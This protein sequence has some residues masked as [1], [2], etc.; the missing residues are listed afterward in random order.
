MLSR[1][2]IAGTSIFISA[3]AGLG[4]H[5]YR[6]GV[7][8]SNLRLLAPWTDLTSSAD[9]QC[10]GLWVKRAQ[11]DPALRCYLTTDVARLCNPNERL[12]LANVLRAYR[13]DSAM[14]SWD[15]IVSVVKPE[16]MPAAR[17]EE[18]QQLQDEIRA[19]VEGRAAPRKEMSALRK[20]TE[21]PMENVSKARP[22]TLDAALDVEALDPGE[23]SG[24]LR[25]IALGGFMLKT[26]FG[27]L[28]GGMV[29]EAFEGVWV[30]RACNGALAESASKLP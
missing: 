11:N 4:F 26:D 5:E 30:K 20:I 28:P 3:L 15:S 25:S 23:I 19:S 1:F 6:A 2:L 24:P 10:A 29:D 27:W 8:G 14:L 16:T 18:V 9:P 12:H 21:K 7:L 22:A 13:W 17:S